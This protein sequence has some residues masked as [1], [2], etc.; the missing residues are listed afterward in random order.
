MNAPQDAWAGPLAKRLIDRFRSKALTYIHVDFTP[1][2]ETLGEVSSIETSYAAAGAVAR[3]MKIER[4]GVYQGQQVEVWVDH[5]IV[6]WPISSNDCLV[7]Q[8]RKWKV[9]EI[10]SYGSG[11]DG[12]ITGPIYLTTLDGKLITTLDGK[13]IVAQGQNS[14]LNGITMYAS[15]VLARM[16]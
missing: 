12:S 4:D 9:T 5:K 7:Y 2:D 13:V 15:R 3:S 16:E 6:P 10:E 14:E 11:T 1:Y 8:G